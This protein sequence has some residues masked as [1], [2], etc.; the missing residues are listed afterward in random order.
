M[1]AL[2]LIRAGVSVLVCE[3]GRVAAEQSSRN[4]GWIRQQGRDF[5]ELP[6]VQEAL[7][8]W[9]FLAALLPEDI[10]FRRTGVMYLARTEPEMAAFADWMR[11]GNAMGT[12]TLLLDRAA[13]DAMLPNRAGWIGALL[14]PSDAQADP[15]LAVPAVA[16]HAAREGATIREGCA[17]RALDL[18]GGRVAGILTERGRVACG[19]VVLAGGAWSG[20]FA[21]RHGISLPQLS[22]RA[23]VARTQP[24]PGPFEG[25]A[26]DDRF[27]FRRGT[28]G[29]YR[30][31]PGGAHDFWIGPAAFRHLRS[32]LPQLRRDY[33]KTRFLPASP[34]GYPDAWGTPRRWAAD[35][36]SPFERCRIL[37]P[38][39]NMRYLARVLDAHAAA[40]PDQGRPLLDEVWA[41]MI[42]VMPD[43]VPVIDRAPAL[44]G[45]TIATGMSGHG[46]GI[47]PG[48]GRVV[49]D[50]ALG[51]DP[52]HDLSRFRLDR[53]TDGS[54]LDLGP[55]L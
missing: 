33:R 1:T 52:G 36:P 20:L 35:E 30:L 18:S 32:Y 12:D 23:S 28:D 50:L 26:A 49:A 15:W 8:H 41:G 46:F 19:Q 31:A 34:R 7:G 43:T 21:A 44:P 38:S 27:A 11:R 13:L 24:M 10:G 16:R 2:F 53:F 51:R 5:A 39:P 47:G 14:T 40:F 3:K 25:G 45:L 48:V 4:W 9:E 29:R 37:N 55:S 22:V 54:R 6:I 42:D 17:V